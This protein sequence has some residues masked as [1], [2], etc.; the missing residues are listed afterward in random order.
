MREAIRRDNE[1]VYRNIGGSTRRL[2]EEDIKLGTWQREVANEIKEGWALNALVTNGRFP[3]AAMQRQI[4]QRIATEFRY[5]DDKADKI[6][7]GE[8]SPSQ[9]AFETTAFAAA[10]FV[11][12]WFGTS[13]SKGRA[14]LS[15]AK[16]VLGDADHCEGCIALE[17]IWIKIENVIYPG[18][19]T[20]C[21]RYCKC[22]L[23]FR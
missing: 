11:G 5:L 17:G 6:E 18:E 20:Q 10:V 12:Y 15:E 14:G 7:D 16:R 1:R 9:I 13:R 19:G 8:K 21:H 22:S 3:D 2:L 23:V 4:N